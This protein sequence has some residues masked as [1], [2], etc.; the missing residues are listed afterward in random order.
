MKYYYLLIFLCFSPFLLIGQD[1]NHFT[2]LE[3]KGSVQNDF[4][5]SVLQML[6]KDKETFI[7]L[8]TSKERKKLKKEFFENNYTKV[9]DLIRGGSIISGDDVTNVVEFVGQE[10]I[11]NNPVL[12]D[13]NIRFY[14]QKSSEINAFSTYQGMIIVTTGLMARIENE[15]QL[16]FILCHEISHYLEQHVLYKYLRVR[17]YANSS[18]SIKHA[19]GFL[20][21]YSQD[22][23]FE[24]DAFGFDM[25]KSTSYSISESISALKILEESKYSSHNIL[26]PQKYFNT[27]FFNLEEDVFVEGSHIKRSKKNIEKDFIENLNKIKYVTHPRIKDRISRLIKLISADKDIDITD[28]KFIGQENAFKRANE[29]SKFQNIQNDLLGHWYIDAIYNSIALLNAYPDNEFIQKSMAKA[30]YGLAKKKNFLN[31]YRDTDKAD[32]LVQHLD[33]LFDLHLN[34]SYGNIKFCNENFIYNLNAK[35]VSTLAI[36]KLMELNDSTV[37]RYILDLVYDMVN[38]HELDQN[39]FDFETP[40]KVA[41]IDS[42]TKVL[43]EHQELVENLQ[44]EIIDHQVEYEKLNEFLRPAFLHLRNRKKLSD[45]FHF[46]QKE[47][48]DKLLITE[49][50]N[51]DLELNLPFKQLKAKSK[52]IDLENNIILDYKYFRKVDHELD[53]RNSNRE[54]ESINNLVLDLVNKNNHNILNLSSSN[55]KMNDIDK[56]NLKNTV[57]IWMKELSFY[58]FYGIIPMTQNKIDN[59]ADQNDMREVLLVSN[60][61]ENYSPEEP[62]NGKLFSITALPYT[63]YIAYKFFAKKENNLLLVG[64]VNLKSAQLS[65]LKSKFIKK[66]LYTQQR[67]AIIKSFFKK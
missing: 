20:S 31:L 39:N 9:Y 63:P 61:T 59:L 8:K 30:L 24:S 64:K 32:F 65:A 50:L 4:T 12:K 42:S 45:M 37:D 33:D 10:I 57:N 18:S 26:V 35:T 14:I 47:T 6:E 29:L 5:A 40:I 38:I 2:P 60:L 15:A 56:L 41:K 62:S 7:S 23:E 1:L 19:V 55:I 28:I 21:K 11:K 27:P 25:F 43:S 54:S 13:K 58:W 67:L 36:Q 22:N 52:N 46:M 34:Q 51:E 66:R 17:S 49:E 48:N 53:Y 3:S 16:A 44:N